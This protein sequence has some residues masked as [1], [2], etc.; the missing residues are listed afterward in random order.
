MDSYG[1]KIID[2]HAHFPIQ[3]APPRISYNQGLIKKYGD[4]KAKIILENSAKYRDEWRRK[5]GFDSPETD[6]HTDDEQ[7]ERWVADI[8]RKG[9]SRVN[10]VM[11]GGNDKLAGIVKMHPERFTG[12]AHH[13]IFSPNSAEELERAVK[14][15]GL[16]GFKMIASALER[17][18]DDEAAYPLWEMAEKLE[19]PV[20]IH[21]GVLG[22]GGGPAREV[23]NLNP[24]SLWKVA[25]AF[26]ALIFVVPHFGACYF[27]ELLQL[28]WACPNV[29]IDTSG[30]NQWM[31]WMPYKLTLRDLFLKCLETIGPDRIIFGTDSSYFPRG[32]CDNYLREQLRE[33]RAIGVEENT[34]RKIFYENAAKLLKLN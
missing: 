12:F 25:A 15:L 33:I 7:A 3:H 8:D 5:W 18:I 31:A 19:V 1:L 20:L 24:L 11:G 27:R 32:F 9:V 2:F 4:R 6:F 26:P 10:F 17:P 22:G 28:C 34:V 13:D 21:F 16:S 23:R 14:E 29:M 30:S